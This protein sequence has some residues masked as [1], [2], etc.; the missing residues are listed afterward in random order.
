[1]KTWCFFQLDDLN[2]MG[3]V[4]ALVKHGNL[5]N[6]EQLGLVSMQISSFTIEMVK[7]LRYMLRYVMLRY[8]MLRY[9][10]WYELRPHNKKCY[11]ISS[12]VVAF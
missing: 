7:T 1:M 8:N 5:G 2:C 6:R 9:M 12:V 4:S 10:L 3:H 11:L